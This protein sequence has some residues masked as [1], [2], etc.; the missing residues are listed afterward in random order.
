MAKAYRATNRLESSRLDSKVVPRPLITLQGASLKTKNDLNCESEFRQKR[1][2]VV[3]GG[4][5][6]VKEANDGKPRADAQLP[7]PEK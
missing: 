1:K 6:K 3:N 5:L 2:L 4:K 7:P